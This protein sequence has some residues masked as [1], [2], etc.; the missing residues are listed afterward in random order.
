MATTTR[1]RKPVELSADEARTIALQAQGLG[2]GRNGGGRAGRVGAMLRRVGA[3]QLDTI[4]VL[5]RSHELVPYARLGAVGRT[6]VEATYWG[7]GHP[8]GGA[9]EYYAHAACVLPVEMWPYFAFRRRAI[10]AR[11][12]QKYPDTPLT[13][14]VLARVGEA[15]VTA[16]DLGGARDGTSGWWSWSRAKQ[17]L[18]LLYMRGD[19]V[20]ATR[21]GWQRVYDTPERAVPTDLLAQDPDDAECYRYLAGVAARALG[22][23]TARD[24]G[25]YFRLCMPAAGSVPDSRKLVERAIDEIGLQ[26]VT[27]EGWTEP[28]FAYADTLRP[29]AR[30]REATR[31]TLLSPFDSLIWE[32]S[33]TQRLFGF[34]LSLEAYKPRADRIHGYFSMPLLHDGRLVGRVDPAREGKTLVARYVSIEDPSSVAAM[35]SALREAATWVG[36]DAVR[37]DAVTPR[38]A[39]KELRRL[40]R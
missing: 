34:T 14:D 39:A 24:I 1:V 4:A 12:R 33:R 7:D 18:E 5:A 27:V 6:D 36:C 10:T 28:A 35:A 20:C 15:Q 26:R 8:G 40:V 2:G 17:T 30:S 22:I 16:N 31:T 21:R 9:F 38:A 19:I 37:V 23:G 11:L 32:R 3:V 29:R 25:D 13:A